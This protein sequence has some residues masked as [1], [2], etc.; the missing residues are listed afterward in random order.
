MFGNGFGIPVVQP[1]FPV[2]LSSSELLVKV[3][4]LPLDLYGEGVV[5][6]FEDGHMVKIKSNEYVLIHKAKERIAEERHVV[7]DIID[8]V[9]DDVVA[10]QTDE[11][12]KRLEGYQRRFWKAVNAFTVY[13]HHHI[14]ANRQLFS[15]K[16][17]FALREKSPTELPWGQQATFAFFDQE[18]PLGHGE[19]LAFVIDK[20]IC[21]NCSARNKFTEMKQ[22]VFKEVSFKW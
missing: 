19:V 2:G 3:Q 7:A 17:E 12:R 4:N 5:V 11:D 22:H 14:E 13:L 18:T 16:K 6:H 15:T 1:L 8:G 10:Q 20:I 21:P 9:I